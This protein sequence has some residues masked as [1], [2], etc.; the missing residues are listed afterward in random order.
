[1]GRLSTGDLTAF[2]SIEVP[3]ENDGK[4]DVFLKRSIEQYSAGDVDFKLALLWMDMSVSRFLDVRVESLTPPQ[5]YF[6]TSTTSTSSQ[7][8]ST[9]S[10][11][12]ASTSTTTSTFTDT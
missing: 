6:T 8:T 1:M 3:A 5:I 12:T 2:Y 11:T 9:S 10:T 4:T 7:T